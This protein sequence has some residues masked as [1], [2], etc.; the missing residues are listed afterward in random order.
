VTVDRLL[1]CMRGEPICPPKPVA[2]TFDDGYADAYDAALPVLQQHGF[3]AT[4]YIV[5]NFVGQP[6]YMSWE[7]VAA[8]NTAGMEIGSHTL[9]HPS[10]T[11][12]DVGELSRQVSES[13]QVLEQRLGI[14]V[15][16][17]CYPVGIYDWITIDY[18][19]AAGYTNAVTTRWDSDYS[20]PLALPRRRIGGGKTAEEFGWTVASP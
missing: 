6:G 8:L 10:L 13:R 20:D 19:R 4:F 1:R 7:Q 15:T 17:F 18:V 12:L 16:S 3:Q 2:L 5:T 14:V 9:D 11:T